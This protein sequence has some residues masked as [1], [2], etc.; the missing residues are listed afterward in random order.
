MVNTESESDAEKKIILWS[1]FSVVTDCLWSR[2]CGH[3]QML[4]LFLWEVVQAF[5]FVVAFP[6]FIFVF[7]LCE[8]IILRWVD[9][10][11]PFK[12]ILFLCHKKILGCFWGIFWVFISV[13]QS[14][15]TQT[16]RNIGPIL[17]ITK[18]PKIQIQTFHRA[19][20]ILKEYGININLTREG[21]SPD[22]IYW[23]R[24]WIRDS[25]KNPE[26]TLK[27]PAKIRFVHWT[28]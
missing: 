10:H 7:K 28:T 1:K 12:K 22:L 11:W 4:I 18:N 3:L 17:V 16:W 24:T 27:Q 13:L 8:V 2:T 15:Q 19:K 23:A 9:W 5:F 6:A 20:L 14:G 26:V 21:L 25:K